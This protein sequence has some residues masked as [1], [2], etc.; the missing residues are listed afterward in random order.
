MKTK[1]SQTVSVKAVT[2]IE[3]SQ[4]EKKKWVFKWLFYKCFTL[5]ELLVVV[6]IIAILAGMLLPALN[7]ARATAH[8]AYCKNNLKQIAL[9]SIMYSDTYNN[10]FSYSAKIGGISC[11][12]DAWLQQL[13]PFL[14]IKKDPNATISRTTTT[15]IC[16]VAAREKP[17][18]KY[19]NLWRHTYGQ[20]YYLCPEV[21]WC[22][23]KGSQIPKPAATAYYCDQGQSP[24]VL[25]KVGGAYPGWWYATFSRGG[26]GPF[27]THGAGVNFA[28]IDGHIGFLKNSQVPAVS[29][30]FWNPTLPY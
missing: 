29:K 23:G 11:S 15:Y 12:G 13:L 25:A 16:P 21:S 28:Y 19:P 24:S 26:L 9:A 20:N 6:A 7:Q 22:V 14:N 4:T 10:Y 2:L 27:M 30:G 8:K 17:V 18:R 1:K 3:G 5:I